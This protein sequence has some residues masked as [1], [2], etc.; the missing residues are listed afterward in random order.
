MSDATYILPIRTTAV[1]PA[2]IAEFRAYLATVAMVVEVLVVDGSPPDVFD[3][4]HEAWASVV[5]CHRAPDPD[6]Q[7]ANGKVNGVETGLR[8]ASFDKVV[9]ADDDVRYDVPSLQRVIELLDEVDLVRPQNYFDPQ[10][11]HARWD[12]ARTLITRAFARD[13]P[14]TVGVRRSALRRSPAYDGNVMFENLE[15]IRTVV[16]DGGTEVA[17]L[18]LYVRRVPPTTRHFWSQRV[19]Q[20]YDELAR[21]ARLVS[22]LA[23]A[24]CLAALVAAR[25]WRTAIAVLLGAPIALAAVGRARGSGRR[26]FGRDA[27]LLAPAWVLER[28]ITSWLAVYERVRFGG[29]R[30]GG[31]TIPIAAHSMRSLRR[32]A[33]ATATATPPSSVRCAREHLRSGAVG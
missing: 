18:D 33:V 25:R 26:V 27:V 14:G 16:A 3:A 7:F 10:P 11:W 29:V 13:L 20:A 12:T 31:Q 1:D 22:E 32:A 6:L 8:L 24:P 15:L 17:P 30:Y 23:V 5:A 21:P 4:H 9:I 28:A 2:A 19:R